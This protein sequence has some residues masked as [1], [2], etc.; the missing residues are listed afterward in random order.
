[1]LEWIIREV[2]CRKAQ[3]LCMIFLL[4]S[5]QCI[6]RYGWISYFETHKK[7]ISNLLT[8]CSMQ[9][10]FISLK[11]CIFPKEISMLIATF[12]S[13]FF[14]CNGVELYFWQNWKTILGIIITQ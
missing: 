5:G 13:D 2:T 14:L 11:A 6:C 3:G 8:S 9:I 12:S 4:F 1:M 10:I 7:V